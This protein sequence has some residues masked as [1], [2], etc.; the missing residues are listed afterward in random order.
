M[1][2]SPNE[3]VRDI[4]RRIF[5]NGSEI[6]VYEKVKSSS[7]GTGYATIGVRTRFDLLM[8]KSPDTYYLPTDLDDSTFYVDR[9]AFVL[10]KG[11]T[12]FLTQINHL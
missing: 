11:S 10:P 9:L 5:V 8:I 12:R 1:L 4:G 3:V 2:M 7:G 6:E